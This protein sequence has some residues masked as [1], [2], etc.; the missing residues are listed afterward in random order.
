MKPK[1]AVLLAAGMGVRLRP[2]TADLP[3]AMALCA[4]WP[5]LAYAADFARRV[6]GPDGRLVVVGGFRADRVRDWLEME[7][8][9]AGFAENP[10]YTKGNLLSVA[11]GLK[12]IDT[13]GGFL[14][15]N[16]DHIYP[17]AFAD[18]LA[19]APGDVVAAVDFDRTL[20][21]DDMKVGLDADRRVA[22]ISKQL[23]DWDA[24]YIGMTLVRPAAA[25]AYR[26]A[27]EAVTR[28]RGDAAVAENVLAELA[29]RGSPAAIC[30]LSG[31]AWLEV[32]TLEDLQVAEVK[33]MDDPE[34][35][36]RSW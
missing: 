20:G 23:A 18:R 22:R 10:D 32:D 3:K 14:L 4:G 27:F 9:E 16:V 33:L 2:L 36:K 30:D 5:L 11:A 15:L 1:N 19:S 34:F 13:D 25:A 8:P 24:G 29:D 6:I 28:T 26:A 35:L 7:A 12:A 17:W 31:L 21:P